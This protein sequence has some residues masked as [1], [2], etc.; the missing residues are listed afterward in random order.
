MIRRALVAALAVGLLTGL[1]M[2]AAAQGGSVRVQL[3]LSETEDTWVRVAVPLWWNGHSWHY[4][5]VAGQGNWLGNMIPNRWPRTGM[6]TEYAYEVYRGPRIGYGEKVCEGTF[7]VPLDKLGRHWCHKIKVPPCRPPRPRNTVDVTIKLDPAQDTWIEVDTPTPVKSGSPWNAYLK[8]GNYGYRVGR[9]SV[10]TGSGSICVPRCNTNDSWTT[11]VAVPEVPVPVTLVTVK[12]HD[13]SPLAGV[14]VSYLDGWWREIGAT[15]AQGQINCDALRSGI[16]VRAELAGTSAQITIGSRG[17]TFYTTEMTAI[18]TTAGGTP[19]GDVAVSYMSGWWRSVGTTN[20]DDGALTCELF[21]SADLN[22]K[23]ELA[24]SQQ[25]RVASV[26]GDGATAGCQD[27]VTFTTTNVAVRAL[28]SA[29]DA[30]PGVT[31]SYESGWSRTIGTTDATGATH[32]ELF[33]EGLRTF[34]AAYGGTVA[35]QEVDIPSDAPTAEVTFATTALR[36]ATKTSADA[37]LGGVTLTYQASWWRTVGVS[38]GPLTAELFPTTALPVRAEY[39][40]TSATQTVDVPGDGI[41]VGSQLALTFHT[42]AVTV[43][44]ADIDGGRV[45][46]VSVSYMASWTRSIG[47]TLAPSGTATAELFPGTFTFSAGYNGTSAQ[48]EATVTGDGAAAGATTLVAFAPTKVTLWYNGVGTAISYMAGWTRSVTTPTAFWMFPGDYTFTFAHGSWPISTVQQSLTI[49]AGRYRANV[50]VLKV[51]DS[52]DT[53]IAPSAA[54]VYTGTWQNATVDPTSRMALAVLPGASMLGTTACSATVGVTRQEKSQNLAANS[55]VEFR[56][57]GV[58][59]EIVSSAGEQLDGSAQI[60][61]SGWQPYAATPTVMSLLPGTYTFAAAYA[62]GRQEKTAQ[63]GLNGEKT[64]RVTFATKLVTFDLLSSTLGNLPGTAQYYASGWKTFA[65]GNTGTSMELLPISYSFAVTYLGAR[66]EKTQ[67]VAS[68]SAVSFATVPVDLKLLSSTGD[69]LAGTAEFY[70]SGWHEFGNTNTTLELL[71]VSYSFAVSYIG[72]RQEKTQNVAVNPT[73]EF[74]TVPVTMMLLSSTGAEL[75][76]AAQYYA[77]GW[78]AFDPANTTT[79]MELLPVS[80]TFAV[81][82]LGARNE[83]T[84]NA[85]TNPVV[86]FRTAQVIGATCTS[87]YASGWK[88]FTSGMELLPGSYT[89]AYGSA[90]PNQTRT[91]ALGVT[92]NVG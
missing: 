92:N 61:A 13:G 69:P 25:V 16:T 6:P 14:T 58:T 64:Q 59:V 40:G 4:V 32:V 50:V 5:W 88:S 30:L 78:R 47:T 84:Q 24:G 9:G 2:P 22:W 20:A 49:P 15:D 45:A 12:D 29:G 33:G 57:V 19:L 54:Q 8:P 34:R 90:G 38:A 48:Q 43:Q 85:G 72:A 81:T 70:A 7:C 89:F 67:N 1:Q 44:A 74:R 79:T 36:L 77:N 91:I 26:P 75:T 11:T 52:T 56:A 87:F 76:G 66:A 60:Y 63:I 23:A 46:G 82:Y 65:D 31:T 10:Q 83:V 68:N 73:V 21:P 27:A 3:E 80:Y 17:I 53:V 71:P 18:A 41:T 28:T 37:D 51:L 55:I 39:N 35:Q 42:T 62:G 86:T